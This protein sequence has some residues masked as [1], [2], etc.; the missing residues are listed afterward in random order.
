MGQCCHIFRSSSHHL[1]S[2]LQLPLEFRRR[3]TLKARAAIQMTAEG[4]YVF[5]PAT[6]LECDLWAISSNCSVGP[7][8][9]FQVV[10]DFNQKSRKWVT[11]QKSS[12]DS[13]LLHMSAF[14]ETYGNCRGNF[15]STYSWASNYMPKHCTA[16][17][18]LVWVQDICSSFADSLTN[19]S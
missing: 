9:E 4:V 18:F 3:K 12:I 14:S 15:H 16:K 5:S 17:C 7:R 13:M 19:W 10:K 2:K 1:T 6:L 11:M 8:Y